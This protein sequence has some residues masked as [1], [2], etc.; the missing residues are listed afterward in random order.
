MFYAVWE[1]TWANIGWINDHGKDFPT[2]TS[3]FDACIDCI[4]AS[5]EKYDWVFF[6]LR[7]YCKGY[8]TKPLEHPSMLVSSG[9][10]CHRTYSTE[11]LFFFNLSKPS[12]SHS[13]D[14]LQTKRKV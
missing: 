12:S 1:C 2:C 4:V 8:Y 10:L 6:S 13:M 7:E 5:A 14:K 11:G 3:Y 9:K